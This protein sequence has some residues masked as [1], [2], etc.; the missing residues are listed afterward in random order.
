MLRL[1]LA[2][3]L[4]T[5]FPLA[6]RSDTT[7][8][9]AARAAFDKAEIARE[10]GRFKDAVGLYLEAIG[11]HPTYYAAHAGHIAAR[12]GLGDLYPA[13]AFYEE[14]TAKEPAD[15]DLMVF[16]AVV[17]DPEK[18]V[19]RLA[20]IAT[21]FPG[22]LRA[23]VEHG[24]ALMQAGEL[25][26]AEDVLK[27]AIKRDSTAVLPRVLL[28]RVYMKLDKLRTARKQF[29]QARQIDNSYVPAQL[30]WAWNRHRDDQTEEALELLDRLLAK[31]NLPNLAAGWWLVAKIRLDQDN[32]AEA[33][34][35]FDR[36][37]ALTKGS[38][39]VLI[40][41]A[42]VLLRQKRTMEAAKLLEKV[43]EASPRSPTALFC[44]GWAYEK[45]AD[46]PEIQ[47]AT[48][49][50]RLAKAAEAYEKCAN[51]DPG[52]RPRD[53]LGFVYLL[54]DVNDKARISFKRARDIDP[55]YAPAL[56]NLG[57]ADDIADNRKAAK[58]KYDEV[59]DRIDRENVR[60][61]IMLALDH[62]L[63][64]SAPKA[65]RMLK[66]ALRVR[67]EDSLAWTFLGDVHMDSGKASRAINAYE[68][69]VEID[70]GN[71]RAWYHLGIAFDE[72]KKK[73]D[74]A[75]AAYENAFAATINPPLDLLV[76]LGGIYDVDV[77]DRPEKALQ[78]YEA[79]MKAGGTEPWVQDR[80]TD[81]KESL[82]K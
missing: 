72:H 3:T 52:V 25:R 69:A 58:K 76:R 48:R 31:D 46:A 4:L 15:V 34:K 8:P 45:A 32:D 42:Q 23:K 55:E 16:K 67:P 7:V 53:S 50:E 12:R 33:L 38:E 75:A 22:N 40:A 79:Y 5:L 65:V 62:W 13:Q 29:E 51:L 14:L 10:E 61:M 1:A 39:P 9:G 30:Y 49:K 73:Y 18:R 37:E 74:D 68:E 35:A 78:Y 43:V 82:G 59:L 47:D 60:A 57:L 77:L 56:N 27:D 21:D 20:K 66:K 64:G 70:P 19:E 24:R 28:G 81:L 44:L 41:K 26:D 6:A 11:K 71:F 54:G 2:A 36:L 63:D 80:I 17:S